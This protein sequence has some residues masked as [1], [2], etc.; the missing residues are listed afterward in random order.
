M[1]APPALCFKKLVSGG[2]G[3]VLTIDGSL[4]EGGGQVL[5]ASLALSLVTGRPF[6][7]VNIRAKRPRPGLRRQHL[8]AVRAAA[9]VSRAEVTGASL[10]SRELAFR[11][12]PVAPGEYELAVGTA[13]SA[14]LVLQ[15]VLPALGLASGPSKVTLAGGTHNP[16]APP[17]EFLERAFAPLLARMGLRVALRLE[18]PGF[19]PAGGGRLT[20]SIEPAA[21]L[22]PL[23]LL[24]RGAIRARR[25]T[26]MVAGLP[27]RIA[28]RE[29]DV[30]A[31]ELGWERAALEAVELPAAYGP[32]NA[33]LVEIE[34]EHVTEVFA[35]FGKKGVPAEK[36][37]RAA[38]VEAKEYLAS[39]AP[40][41]RH[42]ADQILLPLAIAGSGRFRTLAPSSHTTTEIGVIRRFLPVEVDITPAGGM[43][44][45]IEVRRAVPAAGP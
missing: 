25:A 10:G 37:A 40:A 13:G 34:S 35:G 7:I 28:E 11:P 31:A 4:G 45:D 33:V 23:E 3:D 44:W 38:A 26:A 8:A 5:R 39:G 32:G 27:R 41:G 20:A 2:S 42:L 43:L 14:A 24:A 18:R 36:V 19:Y 29:L 15:T 16:L 12:G 9:A 22:A 6:R 1:T 21:A 30:I 17:F